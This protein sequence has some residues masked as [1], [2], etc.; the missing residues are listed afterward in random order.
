MNWFKTGKRV[1][2]DYILS[3]CL[4]YFYAEYIMWNAGLDESQAGVKI[5]RRNVNN[6]RFPGGSG[7]KASPCNMGDLGSI[8]VSGRSSGEG[9][10][11]PF[12][13]SSLENSTDGGAW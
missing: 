7:G 8:A 2:Q 13:Y 1:C 10:G 9:N 4:F 5:A 12:Q 3:P 11:H 6:L